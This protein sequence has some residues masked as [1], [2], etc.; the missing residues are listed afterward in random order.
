MINISWD[1]LSIIVFE[2]IKTS[3]KNLIVDRR[4]LL[5]LKLTITGIYPQIF[6]NEHCF[7][8]AHFIFL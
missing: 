4:S 3:A 6:D 5:K 8:T 1:N 7:A 2:I